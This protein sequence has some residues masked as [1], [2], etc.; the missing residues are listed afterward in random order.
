MPL[1][2]LESVISFTL[3]VHHTKDL[4]SVL[5]QTQTGEEKRGGHSILFQTKS[6]I[7]YYEI[8]HKRPVNFNPDCPSETV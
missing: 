4:N 7:I 2:V 5:C 1:L 6:P 3:N 8:L